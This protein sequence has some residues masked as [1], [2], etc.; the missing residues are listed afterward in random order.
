MNLKDFIA[1][2]PLDKA[3]YNAAFAYLEERE[4]PP[5]WVDRLEIICSQSLDMEQAYDFL[6]K[7]DLL[8]DEIYGK[9]AKELVD[10]RWH[11]TYP[12]V[13]G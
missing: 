1:G 10:G 5:M 2:L 13:E 12:F 9:W 6:D 4:A 7:E 11:Y 8:F 3:Y